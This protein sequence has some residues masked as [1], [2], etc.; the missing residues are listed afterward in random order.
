MEI[1]EACPKEDIVHMEVEE[2]K[3]CGCGDKAPKVE[4]ATPIQE[5]FM[6]RDINASGKDLMAKS[7]GQPESTEGITTRH[8]LTIEP[9]N[10]IQ[11]VDSKKSDNSETDSKP[12]SYL[13][14]NSSPRSTEP[15]ITKEVKHGE[16]SIE[17]DR[18]NIHP[19]EPQLVGVN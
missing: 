5:Q 8:N 15:L 18:I 4:P 2:K 7:K 12:D 19:P 14:T 11:I 9:G 13:Q 17:L 3:P 6:T 10:G 1:E 16:P